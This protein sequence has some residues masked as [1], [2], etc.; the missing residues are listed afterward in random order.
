MSARLLFLLPLLVL[1]TLAA[2]FWTALQREEEPKGGD[3]ALIGKPAPALTLPPVDGRR[4]PSFDAALL[5]GE[6][7]KVVNIWATW[8]APCRIEHPLLME[9]ETQ[10]ITIHGLLYKDTSEKAVTYLAEMGD[11]YQA[12]GI[13]TSGIG[14]IQ[15]GISGVPETFVIDGQGIVRAKIA[16]PLDRHSIDTVIKP[17][18]AEI[19]S[20]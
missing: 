18:I 8:C 4:A 16:G 11:P 1:A 19:N 6:G 15:W 10:G 7:A 5:T 2:A 20:Q 3:A 12:L 9:L 14:G 13:D 17:A